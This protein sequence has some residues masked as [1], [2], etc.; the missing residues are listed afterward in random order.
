MEPP[1]PRSPRL[2]PTASAP[3]MA[4]STASVPRQ[5]AVLA[6]PG[7]GSAEQVGHVGEAEAAEVRGGVAGAVA[8]CADE[9]YGA[10]VRLQSLR[11][12]GEGHVLGP[13]YVTGAEFRGFAHVDE[14]CVSLPPC[15]YLCWEYFL[16]QLF[17]PG[18]SE[19]PACGA[20]DC[21]ERAHWRQLSAR[22]A[23]ASK[24]PSSSMM[25][26]KP[27]ERR[28]L[29]TTALRPPL[30]QWVTMVLSRGSCPR[31]QSTRLP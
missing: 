6:C 24:L 28:A 14:A 21:G 1:D 12:G 26:S 27:A 20:A 17:P 19:D 3:R 11:E 16:V 4:R 31:F 15:G 29:A 13:G 9:D 18:F 10:A 22:T 25:L 8:A 7:C 2:A 30:W 23:Q 5:R